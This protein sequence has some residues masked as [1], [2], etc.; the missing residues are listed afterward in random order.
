MIQR[1]HC[2]PRYLSKVA[3]DVNL[4]VVTVVLQSN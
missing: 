2:K 4:I 3:G 1:V